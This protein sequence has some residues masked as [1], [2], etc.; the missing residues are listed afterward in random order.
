MATPCLI[1]GPRN[2]KSHLVR[3]GFCFTGRIHGDGCACEV[4]LPVTGRLNLSMVVCRSIA[5]AYCHRGRRQ[6]GSGMAC[7]FL[8]TDIG[9]HQLA[10]FTLLLQ[11]EKHLICF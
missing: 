9:P 6:F 3:G 8:A 5:A 4:K 2:Q 10:V 1:D 11:L 7:Y